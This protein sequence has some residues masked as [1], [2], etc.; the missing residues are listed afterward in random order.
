MKQTEYQSQETWV[1]TWLTWVWSTI[2]I[3]VSSSLHLSILNCKIQGMTR[4][5]SFLTVLQS[6]GMFEHLRGDRCLCC[7]LSIRKTVNPLQVYPQTCRKRTR[8]SDHL[9]GDSDSVQLTEERGCILSGKDNPELSRHTSL[10]G[11]NPIP[12]N[13]MRVSLCLPPLDYSFSSFS[14]L[15]ASSFFH[16]R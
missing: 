10:F 1:L 12:R 11:L 16:Y 8:G 4:P 9:Q 15:T 3:W 7:P 2:W 6:L 14:P 5:V 13:I